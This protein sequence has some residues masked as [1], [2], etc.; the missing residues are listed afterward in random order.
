MK[1]SRIAALVVLL[2]LVGNALAQSISFGFEDADLAALEAA[3]WVFIDDENEYLGTIVLETEIVHSGTQALRLGAQDIAYFPTD[4]QFGTLDLWVYDYGWHI[5]EFLDNAYGPRWGL[6]KFGDV[7][8]S[9][10]YPENEPVDWGILEDRCYGIGAGL[11]QKTFLGSDGGFGV[12]WGQTSHMDEA[13]CSSPTADYDP[14]APAVNAGWAGDQSWWSPAW[15]G[16]YF[17][18][19]G[20][21]GGWYHWEIVYETAGTVEVNLLE[22]PTGT[23]KFASNA[24]SHAFDGTTPG[25]VDDICLYGGSTM[26][27]N[28]EPE[29]EF[30]DGIFDD[31]TWTPVDTGPTLQADFDG[32]GDVDL[33]DFAILKLEFGQTV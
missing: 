22:S 25:G 24:G 15:Y 19:D 17:G 7:D 10:Y 23:T 4:G 11:V 2:A 28:R 32:D 14:E 3:G 1:L 30:G 13:V 18:S 26:V 16:P 9:I 33:D 5:Q 29:L 8:V 12:E 27:T 20:R 21:P 6:R 31:V